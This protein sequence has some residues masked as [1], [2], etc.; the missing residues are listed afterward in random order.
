MVKV[1]LE[2]AEETDVSI[3]VGENTTIK[4]EETY[5]DKLLF[6]NA[7][8]KPMASKKL[9]KKCYKLVKKAM[10]HKTYLRNGL[11][12]VQTRLRKGETGI[13]IF[14]GDVTPVDIMCHL[15]AVCEEKGIPYTYTPSRA[16]LGAAMGVKRGTV[17]LL[18]RQNDEYK[19]L[20]DEVKE[21]LSNLNIP[22]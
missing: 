6:I 14:A 17:A 15:P 18:V 11:K 12:D 22:V 9:A 21:E 8:A 7:I 13:C 16:D 4:E 3:K 5:D 1:K 20:Y 10:K 2:H 19:D